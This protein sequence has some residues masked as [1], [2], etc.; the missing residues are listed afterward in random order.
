MIYMMCINLFHYFLSISMIKIKLFHLIVHT[1]FVLNS[2]EIFFK[3]SKEFK[4]NFY[5]KNPDLCIINSPLFIPLFLVIFGSKSWLEF[6]YVPRFL[7]K[8]WTWIFLDFSLS[9]NMYFNT[10]KN[11]LILIFFLN[12]LK[13]KIK[14]ENSLEATD[15]IPT[16][17]ENFHH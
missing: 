6:I 9:L 17:E 10:W 8:P 1:V 14:G 7:F 16:K 11:I 15:F 12:V 4:V 3:I 13:W 2:K 5:L